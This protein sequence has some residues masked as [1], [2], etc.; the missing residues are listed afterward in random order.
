VPL[1]G[2]AD[3]QIPGLDY[4]VT[5]RVAYL[6]INRPEKLNSLN[7]AMYSGLR[8]H[9]IRADLDDGV[10]IIVL[11]STGDRA[12]CTGGDLVEG[13]ARWGSENG[14]AQRLAE[15]D[16]IFPFQ[17][18]ERCSKTIL[19]AVNGLAQAAGLIAVLVSDLVIASDQASFKV[20]ETL[21]GLTEPYIPRRLAQTVGLARARWMI[22]TAE[23]IDAAQ[24]L[25]CGL[26]AK[27]VPHAQ[28]NEAVAQTV[29]ALR[30][31]GPQSRRHYKRMINETLPSIT[32]DEYMLSMRSAEAIEGMR[33]FA[34]KRPPA[35]DRG[36]RH[37]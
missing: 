7:A 35:W 24:A 25:A 16:G 11:R 20:P 23:E 21:R 19:T 2:H 5:D 34:E 8:T 31:T 14:L 28:L 33:S 1:T 15:V 13:V 17:A 9:V 22:Y 3:E 6:T 12:F 32:L 10:D 4:E 27:V 37:D 18:F 30:R 29:T 36:P 26:V